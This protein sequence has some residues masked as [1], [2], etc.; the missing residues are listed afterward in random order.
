MKKSVSRYSRASHYAVVFLG[1]CLL[2]G[3]IVLPF[4]RPG[5]FDH[6]VAG[7]MVAVIGL[8]TVVL[9]GSKKWWVS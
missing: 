6:L 7:V 1:V 9:F 4:V 5:D 2:V 3:G 8:A